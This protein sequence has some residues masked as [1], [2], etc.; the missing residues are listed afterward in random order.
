MNPP[1]NHV[2]LPVDALLAKVRELRALSWRLVQIGA[3]PAGETL[4]LNYSFDRSG[5]L[6]NLRVTVP[7]TGARV[8]SIS[9]VYWCAFIYENEL[10]DLFRVQIDGIAVDYHG[11][12]YRTTVPFP[13]AGRVQTAGVTPSGTVT[14]GAA[15]KPAPGGASGAPAAQS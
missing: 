3:T 15:S 8:P 11:K 6:L 14:T 9:G 1:Q 7:A 13:F 2:A 12:F 5:E 10:H 4:E